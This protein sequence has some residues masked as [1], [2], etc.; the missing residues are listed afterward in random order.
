MI[1]AGAPCYRIVTHVTPELVLPG[2]T[3]EVIARTSAAK[4]VRAGVPNE[5]A[6]VM[7][8]NDVFDVLDRIPRGILP[9]YAHGTGI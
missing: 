8:C 5:N 7:R 4:V 6:W 2:A 1:D 3:I 9:S